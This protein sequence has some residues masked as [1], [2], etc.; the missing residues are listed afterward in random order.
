MAKKSEE[1]IKT[2]DYPIIDEWVNNVWPSDAKTATKNYIA[3]YR[4]IVKFRTSMGVA[5]ISRPIADSF[6]IVI[7][8]NSAKKCFVVW[9][10]AIQNGIHNGKKIRLTIGEDGEALLRKAIAPDS[11]TPFFRKI[12]KKGSGIEY[13]EMIFLV[14]QNAIADFCANYKDMIVPNEEQIPHG[15]TCLYAVAGGEIEY[16]QGSA[17]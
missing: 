10:A 11:I 13:V 12:R 1:Y 3:D 8:Y 2:G 14:G 9:N 5:T 7:N 15:K 4:R 16:I 6:Q 17:L